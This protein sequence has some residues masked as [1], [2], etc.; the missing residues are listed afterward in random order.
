MPATSLLLALERVTKDQLAVLEKSRHCHMNCQNMSCGWGKA[1]P[2][3][4]TNVDD[5]IR[6]TV[7]TGKRFERG[8]DGAEWR[9][10]G[11]RNCC[12]GPKW[13]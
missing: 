1:N 9:V 5:K 11:T 3:Y 13:R 10:E 6:R 7:M 4:W 8:A 2:R 12:A